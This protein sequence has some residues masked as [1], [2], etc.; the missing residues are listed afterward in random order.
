VRHAGD[1]AVLR[2]L[3]RGRIW[4]AIP[5]LVV[6]EAPERLVLWLPPGVSTKAAVGDLFAGWSLAERVFRA[7]QGILRITEP[8]CG[9][10]I[11]LF[12]HE[13]GS[14][15]GWYL[16]LEGPLR[17]WRHGWDFEDH[18]LDAWLDADGSMRWLDEDELARAVE[19]GVYTREEARA[20]RKAGRRGLERLLS[21]PPPERTGWESWQPDPA[22]SPPCLP[23]GWDDALDPAGT[24]R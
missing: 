3:F 20:I 9:Y 17:P 8:G 13:D 21:S 5:A 23:E 22:W 7:P 12:W 1:Y 18:L 16:N 19:L 2:Q 24:L 14:F 11:L 10:S 6:E 15:K 4:S